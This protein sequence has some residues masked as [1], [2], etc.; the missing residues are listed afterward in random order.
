MLIQSPSDTELA[1]PHVWQ[2]G[3][4]MPFSLAQRRVAATVI[5]PFHLGG[6][7]GEGV[8]GHLTASCRHH[9]RSHAIGPSAAWKPLFRTGAVNPVNACKAEKMKGEV[10][11]EYGRKDEE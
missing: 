6:Q 11:D 2:Q 8:E 10:S 5:S 9:Y 4:G 7:M 3:H 1:G